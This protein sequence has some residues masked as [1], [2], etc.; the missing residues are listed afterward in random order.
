MNLL[1][2]HRLSN[3][4]LLWKL[5]CSMTKGAIYL[6]VFVLEAP[7]RVWLLKPWGQHLM[8]RATRALGDLGKIAPSQ[9]DSQNHPQAFFFV[10][11]NVHP[12]LSNNYGASYKT[13]HVLKNHEEHRNAQGLGQFLLFSLSAGHRLNQ[14]WWSI[15]KYL[16]TPLRVITMLHFALW[17]GCEFNLIS[18][19]V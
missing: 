13:R 1:L 18:L 2:R 14:D 12:S 16:R 9:P 10:G 11:S 6:A 4:A 19:D 5:V 15:T 17:F 3:I 8:C 7:F